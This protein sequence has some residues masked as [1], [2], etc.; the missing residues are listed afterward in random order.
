VPIVLKSGSPNLLEPSGP[1]QDSIG[2]AFYYGYYFFAVLRRVDWQR[3]TKISKD[4]TFEKTV[5]IYQSPW[6]NIAEDLNFQQ[7]RSNNFKTQNNKPVWKYAKSPY[8]Y[9]Q[10]NQPTRYSIFSSLLP[11]V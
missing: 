5:H 9:I 1:V 2:I 3:F 10:L 11:V 8:S 7:N 6:L 4:G